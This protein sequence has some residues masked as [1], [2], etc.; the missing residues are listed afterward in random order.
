MKKIILVPFLCVICSLSFAQDWVAPYLIGSAVGTIASG[1]KNNTTVIIQQPGSTTAWGGQVQYPQNGL[2]NYPHYQ[3]PGI[4]MRV[5]GPIPMRVYSN[6]R[7][8]VYSSEK[9]VPYQPGS[10]QIESM[11]AQ[12]YT[13]PYLQNTP[14]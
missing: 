10:N 6:E 4:P 9:H 5:Y 2:P 12:Q 8:P 7:I 3:A 14:R 13:S 11:Q 1:P